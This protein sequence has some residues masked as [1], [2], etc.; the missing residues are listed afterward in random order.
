MKPIA[1]LACLLA[2]G[3][4]SETEKKCEKYASMEVRCGDFPKNQHDTTKKLAQGF[5]EEALGGNDMLNIKPEVECA[6]KASSCS[7]YAE[8]QEAARGQ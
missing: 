2:F 6:Q 4:T 3:C 7:E 5:C 1:I 8:C